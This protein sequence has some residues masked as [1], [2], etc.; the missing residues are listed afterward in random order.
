MGFFDQLVNLH[1]AAIA[2]GLGFALTAL[3]CLF[4]LSGRGRHGHYDGV[5]SQPPIHDFGGWVREASGFVPLG[6]KLWII[7]IVAWA[8]TMVG[9]VFHH[10]YRY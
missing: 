10:G 9:I 1:H 7:A 4:Y 5:E 2:V 6:L 3:V 8:I